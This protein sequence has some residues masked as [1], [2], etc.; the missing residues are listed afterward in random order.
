MAYH[1]LLSAWEGMLEGQKC[2][3]FEDADLGKWWDCSHCTEVVGRE[4]FVVPPRERNER[5]HSTTLRVVPIAHGG[6]K[7]V[8]LL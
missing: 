4:L 8:W 6:V 7:L 3:G 1:F 2:S 5:S